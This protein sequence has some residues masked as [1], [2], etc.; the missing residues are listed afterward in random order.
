[1]ANLFFDHCFTADPGHRFLRKLERLGFTLR[2]STVEH[3]GKHFCRFIGFNSP[4][5]PRNF[6]YLEFI[7]VGRGGVPVR[8]PGLSLSTARDLEQFHRS[9]KR[10]RLRASFRHKNYDWKKDDR[11][12][13]PG[14]NF[15]SFQGLGFTTLFPWLTEYEPHPERPRRMSPIRHANGVSRIVAAEISVNAAGRKFFGALLGSRL[16]RPV[17]VGPQTLYFTSGTRTR[18][19]RVVLGARSLAGLR[20]RGLDLEEGTWRGRKALLIP[21]PAGMWDLAVIRL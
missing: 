1:M 7:H 13:Q 17:K 15:V 8:N 14:W 6:T 10:S 19:T 18:L 3:P 9:L 12:R 21:N 11:S 5:S 4:A 2:S 16:D 20:R